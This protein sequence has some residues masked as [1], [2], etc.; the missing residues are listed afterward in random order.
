M[1]NWPACI[2][3]T[4]NIFVGYLNYLVSDTDDYFRDA[5]P[6]EGFKSRL[7]YSLAVISLVTTSPKA[8]DSPV[9][10]EED[11]M[12]L[13]LGL[14]PA[15]SEVQACWGVFPTQCPASCLGCWGTWWGQ[16][17]WRPLALQGP[18]GRSHHWFSAKL[19]SGNEQGT[20]G[21]VQGPSWSL[22]QRH[23]PLD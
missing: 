23:M 9:S 17:T 6:C 10:L 20:L 12:S 14:N 4:V 3:E 22:F 15:W 11:R 13:H 18:A 1:K 5:E 8:G 7:C 21:H 2:L 16:S 19:D